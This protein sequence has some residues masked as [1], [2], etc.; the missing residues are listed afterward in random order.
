MKATTQIKINNS[1]T[2]I[3]EKNIGVSLAIRKRFSLPV[4]SRNRE[5]T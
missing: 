5:G 4:E 3:M 1:K 2:A